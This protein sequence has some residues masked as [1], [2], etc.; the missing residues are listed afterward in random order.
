MGRDRPFPRLWGRSPQAAVIHPH[1]QPQP[2][3]KCGTNTPS[4]SAG[5]SSTAQLPLPIPA[6]SPHPALKEKL[7]AKCKEGSAGPCGAT[8]R[9]LPCASPTAPRHWGWAWACKSELHELQHLPRG[10]AGGEPGEG[11][12]RGPAAD[13]DTAGGQARLVWKGWAAQVG[14]ERGRLGR[15]SARLFGQAAF[16]ISKRFF[17]LWLQPLTKTG[18]QVFT[19][20]A[21]PLLP[22]W[23]ER[24]R[25]RVLQANRRV[26]FKGFPGGGAGLW[27][28]RE[29]R[30]L[31]KMKNR[32]CQGPAGK[33]NPGLA[34]GGED[35]RPWVLCWGGRVQ[36]GT[37]TNKGT[38][39]PPSEQSTPSQEAAHDRR[40]LMCCLFR[41][42][43]VG[44]KERNLLSSSTHKTS[45]LS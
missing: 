13:E 29:Q 26:S 1:T 5:S 39:Q 11:G 43:R 34:S 16:S 31:C 21:K 15:A 40:H 2:G 4:P 32:K 22:R 30:R 41:R 9:A 20:S 37:V 7:E 6:G 17:P 27:K 42:H 23:P 10:R 24:H 8:A 14:M 45:K 3:K 38:L 36:T 33:V 44:Y 25:C 28:G 35:R 12:E 18:K 19:G